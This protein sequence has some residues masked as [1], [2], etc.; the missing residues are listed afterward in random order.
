MHH[1]GVLPALRDESIWIAGFQNIV[2]HLL[3]TSHG[4]WHLDRDCTSQ[5]RADISAYTSF[6]ETHAQPLIDLNLYVSSE[7]YHA[8]TRPAYS[9]ILLWPNT[10]LLPPQRRA[11]AKA[12]TDHLNFSSLDLDTVDQQEEDRLQKSPF[13][14]GTE[15]PTRLLP[16][17]TASLAKKR[18]QHAARFRLDRFAEGCLEPL[19]D[20]LKGKQY[21]LSS[22]KQRMT[23]LDCLALGYLA[24][25]LVPAMP[26]PWLA[27]K[28]KGSYPDLC[29][30]V[31][32]GVRKCFGLDFAV[33]AAGGRH[34]G[35]TGDDTSDGT[36]TTRTTGLPW[37]TPTPDTKIALTARLLPL[38]STLPLFGPLYR[39]S[40]LQPSPSS[41][42]ASPPQHNRIPLL[43]SLTLGLTASVAAFGLRVLWTGE[44]PSFDWVRG[45]RQ[46]HRLVLGWP[47][48]AGGG[49]VKR[50]GEMGEAG[51]VLG[52]VRV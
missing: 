33:V 25:A 50:L 8:S 1:A 48:G 15:I 30:Y 52:G 44:V 7:N 21:L 37:Q 41:S 9:H 40:P 11:A 22:D 24:L 10:W 2:V 38:L 12:R 32:D 46:R 3:E 29:R 34:Q 16:R 18:G 19:N 31:D 42:S 39:P 23:S 20:L 47:F 35:R 6:L 43:P 49:R 14:A 27:N 17:T 26:Q 45:T 13:A 5:D 51:R 36:T 28:M 4:Q